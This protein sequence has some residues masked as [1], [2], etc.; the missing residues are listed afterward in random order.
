MDS[1]ASIQLPHQAPT[2]ATQSKPN[3]T[4]HSSTLPLSDP[5]HPRQ[6]VYPAHQGDFES[7]VGIPVPLQEA[8]ES[9][10]DRSAY[11][12]VKETTPVLP[13]ILPDSSS[14]DISMTD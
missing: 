6:H 13:A 12:H 9:Q 1:R 3:L 11:L 4:G 7:H 10:A 8:K 2:A 14:N 5:S